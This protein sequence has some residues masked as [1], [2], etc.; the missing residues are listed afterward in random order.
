ML[1]S[2]S[3]ALPWVRLKKVNVR[4]ERLSNHDVRLYF[5]YGLSDFILFYMAEINKMSRHTWSRKLH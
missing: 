5:D 1:L 2:A 3:L 4:S